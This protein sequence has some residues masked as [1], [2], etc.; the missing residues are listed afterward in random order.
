MRAA[1]LF[2]TLAVVACGGPDNPIDL[3]PDAAPDASPDAPTDAPPDAVSSGF[4]TISGDCGVLDDAEWDDATPF[5]FEGHFD[6]AADRYDDPA[7]RDLLTKGGQI[8]VATD[9]AGGSSVYSEVFAFEWLARCEGASL[10]K[11]E[12][13]IVYDVP[14]KKADILVEIDGRKVGV[15]VTRAVMYPFGEPYTLEAATTLFQRKLDDIQ[16]ATAQVSDAD[17]WER[18]MLSVLAYDAQHAEIAMQAWNALAPQTRDDTILIVSITDGDDDFIYT[19][20]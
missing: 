17:A 5:W 9:N 6:F 16:L 7:E 10:V 19:D 12:T 13:Q 18:Q 15:S 14:G 3:P 20:N 4:G 2:V 8:I 11:T 1:P